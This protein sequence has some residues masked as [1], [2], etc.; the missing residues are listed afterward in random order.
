ML[1]VVCWQACRA[2]LF[3]LPTVGLPLLSTQLPASL[4]RLT[5][6]EDLVLSDNNLQA[7]RLSVSEGPALGVLWALLQ[8]H[9]AAG[10]HV[11]AQR[12]LSNPS[13]NRL[14]HSVRCHL[15]CRRCCPAWPACSRS[16]SW[17]AP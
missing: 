7:A 1:A 17:A 16:R 15:S 10:P 8:G 2:C 11:P 3:S 12:R 9:A 5:C 14:M 4:G 6:L 13:N